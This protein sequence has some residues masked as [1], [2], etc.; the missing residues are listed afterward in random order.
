MKTLYYN[1]K[2]YLNRHKF[3]EAIIVKDNIIS[4]TGKTDE[5]INKEYD[6]KIDLLGRVVI[7][8]FNDSHLHLAYIAKIKTQL[9]LYNAKSIKEI[10]TLTKE[11]A[12]NNKDLEVIYAIGWNKNNFIEGEIRDIKKEDIDSLNI[13]KPI[14]LSR[15]C[16]HM[17][18]ANQVAIDK[19]NIK[20]DTVIEGGSFDVKKGHFFENAQQPLLDLV[21]EPDEERLYNALLEVVE[22]SFSKGLT[23]VHT[24][25]LGLTQ[26]FD[27]ILKLYKKYY[28]EETNHIRTHHQICFK[29]TSDFTLFFNHYNEYKK[30]ESLKF[31]FGPLKLFKDGSLG[32]RSAL[33]KE[34]YLDR[35]HNGV[36]VITKEEVDEYLKIAYKNDYSVVTHVIGDL[37]MNETVKSYIPYIKDNKNKYRWGLIHAQLS[38]ND[39]IDL[40]EKYNVH[41]LVQPIFLKSDIKSIKDAVTHDLKKTSYAFKTFIDKGIHMSFGTDSPVEDIDPFENIYFALTRKDYDGEVFYKE[42]CVDIF[43]AVDSYTIASSYDEFKEEIKGRIKEGYLADFIVLDRDI[44][45]ISN[46]E[47]K[48]T[49]VDIT[50]LDGKIVYKRI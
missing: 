27:K 5:L 22:Y 21:G 13:D 6:K 25:D 41:T 26:S 7:P 47:I 35:N 15:A 48:D 32:G 23:S 45:E 17:L 20:E 14:I 31:T 8:S 18:V 44:F 50:V 49:K 38:D 3:S 9:D 43:D 11:Y 39:D 34:N 1:G 16:A 42:Q 28:S 29:T 40:I 33:V 12:I 24:N 19:S 30:L 10:L 37:A 36:E 46:E 4:S 2:I